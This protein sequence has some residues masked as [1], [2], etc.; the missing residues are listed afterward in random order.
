MEL[1]VAFLVSLAV[2]G[3]KYLLKLWRIEA[4]RAGKIVVAGIVSLIAAAAYVA[5]VQVGYW[6]TVL[7]VLVAAAGIHGLILQH[8]ED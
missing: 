2:Q 5:L 6:E 1:I 4:S 3:I 7:K 8:F